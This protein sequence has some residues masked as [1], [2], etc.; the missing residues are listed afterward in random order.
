MHL[1]C[2]SVVSYHG[3]CGNSVKYTW[4]LASAWDTAFQIHPCKV[5]PLFPTLSSGE[6]LLNSQ[7]ETA[8]MLVSSRRGC[9]PHSHRSNRIPE[10]GGVPRGPAPV[11]P[12]PSPGGWA[13]AGAL[14]SAKPPS[15]LGVSVPG[16]TCSFSHWFPTHPQAELVT[17]TVLFVLNLPGSDPGPV[18]RRH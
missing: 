13:G 6:S 8:A 10:L 7:I 9:A 18:G 1:R 17:N 5:S 3:L 4:R 14:L 2:A 12:S 11:R 16:L 15:S